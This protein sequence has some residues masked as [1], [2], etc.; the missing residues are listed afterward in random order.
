MPII[1]LGVG[2]LYLGY[3]VQ[4][5]FIRIGNEGFQVSTGQMPGEMPSQGQ[6]PAPTQAPTQMPA[7]TPAQMPSAQMPPTQMTPTQMPPTQAPAPTPAQMPPTVQLNAAQLVEI[8]QQM[9]NTLNTVSQKVD[10]ILNMQQMSMGQPPTGQPPTGQPPTGQPPMANP[11]GFQ[12]YQ[13]PY[14]TPSPNTQ[15]TY[16]FRLGKRSLVDDVLRSINM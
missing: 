6:M 15:Q 8:A 2:I 9:N 12:S 16:E 11:E 1:L 10:N 4:N 14:N 13:N 3:L 7:P 5:N